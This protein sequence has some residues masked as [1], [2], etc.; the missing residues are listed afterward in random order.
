MGS[1]LIKAG[2]SKL[3]RASEFSTICAYAGS[4][5]DVSTVLS[6]QSGRG[7]WIVFFFFSSFSSFLSPDIR[8]AKELLT[9]LKEKHRRKKRK[10][11][12]KKKKKNPFTSACSKW[13]FFFFFFF[14]F[15]YVFVV[16]HRWYRRDE[17][18][19]AHPLRIC[20][21]DVQQ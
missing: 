1:V 20:C 17:R 2:D 5:M 10:K 15:S 4:R 6:C 14:F 7:K 13:M 9:A 21:T 19:L 18:S 16:I 3:K 12:K 8:G 11:K